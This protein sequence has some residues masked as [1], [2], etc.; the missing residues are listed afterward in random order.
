[1]S[2]GL[3]YTC[4]KTIPEKITKDGDHFSMLNLIEKAVYI[5]ALI[6]V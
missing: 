3:L 5:F 4:I 1:M 6:V 2:A